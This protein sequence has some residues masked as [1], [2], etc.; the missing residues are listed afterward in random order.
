MRFSFRDSESCALSNCNSVSTSAGGF[1]TEDSDNTSAPRTATQEEQPQ[2]LQR[3][4][5]S[6]PCVYNLL[7][8]QRGNISICT[9]WGSSEAATSHKTSWTYIRML[10]LANCKP[11]KH[12]HIITHLS[13]RSLKSGLHITM[14]TLLYNF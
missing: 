13:T 4:C 6:R 10:S 3:S 12:L 5:Y 11:F 2:G 14:L 7:C 9:S 8:H 1:S